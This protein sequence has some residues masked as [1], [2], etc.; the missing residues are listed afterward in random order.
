MG[1]LEKRAFQ[2]FQDTDGKNL[3]NEINTLAGF[4][5]EFDMLGDTLMKD[6][7]IDLY[8]EGFTKVYFTPIIEA[9][10]VI[11]VDDMGKKA[12]KD[13]LKK[14]VMKNDKDVSSG[15][16]AYTFADGVL[17]VDHNPFTNI[18]N[19]DERTKS[20]ITCLSKGM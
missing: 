17:T 15:D 8:T 2:A 11:T 9:L 13:T 14:I 19:V 10:K 5:V 7:R 6:D 16:Y 1:L 12:L 4:T 20:L 18:D 3:M